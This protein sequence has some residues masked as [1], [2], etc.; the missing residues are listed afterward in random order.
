MFKRNDFLVAQDRLFKERVP[1]RRAQARYLKV[2]RCPITYLRV[3]DRLGVG[4]G[5][6]V[7]IVRG[8][9]RKDH[10]YLYLTSPYNLPISVA[11]YIGCPNKMK[12]TSTTTTTTTEAEGE[13]TEVAHTTDASQNSTD[14]A[15]SPSGGEAT[16]AEGA[17]SETA[18]EG[19]AETTVEGGAATEA[20]QGEGEEAPAE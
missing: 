6:V 3:A 15:Q 17:A 8:G 4:A 5:P 13:T 7:K 20:A 9:L 19:G 16:P 14:E 11:I 2:V 1:F 18:V 12:V 10:I